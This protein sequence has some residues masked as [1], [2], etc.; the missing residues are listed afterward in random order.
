MELWNDPATVLIGI[1][2]KN[3]HFF[4]Y[5][6]PF[7]N[8]NLFLLRFPGIK[9]QTFNLRPLQEF[10][11]HYKYFCLLCAYLFISPFLFFS[12]LHIVH[13]YYQYANTVYFLLLVAIIFSVCSHKDFLAVRSR[14]RLNLLL[15]IFIMSNYI[16]FLQ[17]YLV[18]SYHFFGENSDKLDAGRFVN[19]NTKPENVLLYQGDAWSSAI[20]FHSLRRSVSID[21]SCFYD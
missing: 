13:E 20:P 21:S 10:I 1:M 18:P 6:S 11:F 16:I 17:I 4:S 3:N 19:Q 5:H 12:N 7:A 2:A 15:G 14:R 9:S 8:F